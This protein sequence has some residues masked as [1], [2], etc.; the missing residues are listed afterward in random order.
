MKVPKVTVDAWKELYQ[1]AVNFQSLQPWDLLEDSEIFGVKDPLTGEIGYCCVLGA[2]GQVFALCMYRGSEGLAFHQR[3]QAGEFDPEVDD[4]WAMQNALMVEFTDRKDL[5]KEDLAVIK[6]VGFKPQKTNHSPSYPC[7]RNHTPGFAPWFISEAEA[8]WLT[9]ALLCATDL[10]ETV[11][12]DDDLLE[13]E[14]PGHVLTYFVRDTGGKKL[15]WTRKWQMPEPY[16]EP[17]PVEVPLNELSL[18]KIKSLRLKQDSAWEADAFFLA[19]GVVLDKDRPYFSRLAMVAHK[20]SGFI[21][22]MEM[23]PS[24]QPPYITLRDVFLGALEKHAALPVELHVRDEMIWEALKPLT[25]AL[26][27]RLRLKRF[28]PMIFEAKESLNQ[29]ARSG[30][31]ASS[32]HRY[33]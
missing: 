25:D 7:F 20:Q 13:R 22:N 10:V 14:K 26:G 8:K 28:L 2:A 15:S 6:S 17:V 23:L 5:E 11:K 30:F 19:G 33:T 12:E 27:I 18:R 4:A 1:A 29:E 24:E 32:P 31:R 21:F 16:S 3:M 9:F